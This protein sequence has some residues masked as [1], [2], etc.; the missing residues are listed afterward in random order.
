MRRLVPFF[1]PLALVACSASHSP[2]DDAGTPRPDGCAFMCAPPVNC[3]YVG[4]SG[5]DCG[6]LVCDL[7]GCVP[8]S[9]PMPAP[10]CE[11]VG[12]SA[13]DCGILICDGID[14]CVPPP[15]AAPPPGCH[16]EGAGPCTCGTL[17]CDCAP[18]S[19]VDPTVVCFDGNGEAPTFDITV[20]DPNACF[21]GET[22][23]CSASQDETGGIH[24][25]VRADACGDLCEACFHELRGTCRLDGVRITPSP[26]YDVTING[27]RA[28]S[29]LSWGYPQCWN[30]AGPVGGGLLCSWPPDQ[31]VTTSNV[32]VPSDAGSGS[33]IVVRADVCMEDCFTEAA[34]C[35]ITPTAVGYEVRPLLRS[36]DCPTCGA[37]APGCIDRSFYCTLP[38][39]ENGSY[40]IT[41]AGTTRTLV[42]SGTG[43]DNTICDDRTP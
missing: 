13:C 40:A 21:C 33:P 28:L 18:G 32:C 14:A 19:P 17:V 12:A 43:A 34:G 27:V 11:W 24:V 30:P 1:F 3:H 6:T 20:V 5:C 4:G 22:I 42:V 23:A 25:D 2:G 37:C 35:E 39:L 16:Y 36:C 38:P 8:P 41:V 9:C 10:G 31:S 29:G 7:D 26:V 15:C